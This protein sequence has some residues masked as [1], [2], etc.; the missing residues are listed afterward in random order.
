MMSTWQE[1]ADEA[2]ALGIIQDV[3]LHDGSK[4]ISYPDGVQ[5]LAEEIVRLRKE[6]QISYKNYGEK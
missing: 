3:Y 4:A 6:L 2:G 1:I 5:Q